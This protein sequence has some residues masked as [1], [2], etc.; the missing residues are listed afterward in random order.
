ML[1]FPDAPTTG[2]VFQGWKWDSAKWI[3]ATASGD[4]TAVNA[5]TGLSGGGAS[6]DVTLNLTSPVAIA[7]GGTNATSAGAALTSLG[8]YPASNPSGY[9]TGGPYLPTAGGT[10][11]G[12]LSVSYAD[13]ATMQ[14]LVAGSTKGVRFKFNSTQAMIDG[15]D[16][17]GNASVQPLV[18]GGSNLAFTINGTEVGRFAANSFTV[19]VSSANMVVVST[20]GF[21]I[22]HAAGPENPV[23]VNAPTF[24][25]IKYQ[26]NAP[27][28]WTAGV[29]NTSWQI[30]DETASGATR[31]QI[32]ADGSCWCTTGTW[33]SLSDR[34][35]KEDVVPYT[36]GLADL[37]PLQP[38]QFKYNGLY[39][40]LADGTT[41]YGFVA[42]EI[43]PYVPECVSTREWVS[44]QGTPAEPVELKGVDPGRLIYACINA[45]KELN[46]QIAALKAQL[47]A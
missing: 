29:N 30:T 17:T 13:D 20:T 1:N 12:R 16:Q 41:H 14:M 26:T 31:L 25:R 45:I 6:G 40:T 5:G 27:R 15:V 37:L 24:A 18:I 9:V 42:Q 43:E 39:G 34:A 23:T 38:M 32:N 10:E 8:A 28:L 35:V 47:P 44:P 22:G 36:R 19:T 7:N 11:T 21:A 33:S 2:Q 4:I 46:D 3:A